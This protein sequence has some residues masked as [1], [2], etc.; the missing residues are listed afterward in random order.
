MSDGDTIDYARQLVSR[1]QDDD[2]FRQ[3][4]VSDPRAAVKAELGIDVPASI[5]LR[6]IEE[7][8][9]EVVLVLP[10]AL[11]TG[12][13]SDADLASISGGDGDNPMVPSNW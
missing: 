2:A 3:Q 1:A 8:A 9:N 6:V 13:L 5:Q 7:Q 4:L 11:R 12:T 10:G